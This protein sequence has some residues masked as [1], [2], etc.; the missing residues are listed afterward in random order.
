VNHRNTVITPES[1]TGSNKG[2]QC[3]RR[4]WWCD[5]VGLGTL[6]GILETFGPY[7]T[8]NGAT[9]FAQSRNPPIP[10]GQCGDGPSDER[11]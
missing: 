5:P 9:T 4:R 1:E 11:G 6:E 7:I 8:E 2:A 3:G 10:T